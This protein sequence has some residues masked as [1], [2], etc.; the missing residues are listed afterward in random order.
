MGFA[1]AR[2]AVLGAVL[3]GAC[4]APSARFEGPGPLELL[5]NVDDDDGDGI[6]DG[7]D[8]RLNG[9]ADLGDLTPV[10]LSTRCEGQRLELTVEP[11]EHLRVFSLV[12]G[13]WVARPP[14]APVTCGDEVLEVEAK[15][16]RS[17]VWNGAGRLEVRSAERVLAGVD[18][19]VVPVLFPDVTKPATRLYAVD[20]DS[21]DARPNGTVV[22]A[23]E[24]AAGAVPLT[25][26]AGVDY[27]S[28]RWMQDAISA[29]VQVRRTPLGHMPTLLA[30]DRATGDL[31]LGSFA[32]NQ[33]GPDLGLVRAGRDEGNVLSYGGNLDVIPPHSGFALGR[34]VVGGGGA[35]HM[36][37]STR[38]WLEAQAAQAPVL[39]LSTE[40]LETGHL[41][42]VLT[43]VPAPNSKLGWRAVVASPRLAIRRIED[44]AQSGGGARAVRGRAG[45]RTVL[46][47]AGDPTLHR[48]NEQAQQHL[49]ALTHALAAATG[50][51]EA[52]IVTLPQ[53]FEV[54][55][56]G[57]LVPLHPSTVSVVV[58]GHRVLLLSADEGGDVFDGLVRERLA[59]LGLD[60]DFVADTAAYH[61]LGG[62][63]HCGVEIQRRLP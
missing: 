27:H 23:L 40:W 3:V 32:A 29:G 31:G 30:M 35:R 18:V 62:G 9:P 60:C 12:D 49:D 57:L 59:T 56:D 51:S 28:E 5:A 58:V 11:A 54:S 4:A 20:V 42:E 17:Q 46:E 52:D 55:R 10:T 7:L 13:G 15:R 25:L 44:L 6:R 47:L 63:L 33:L 61:A 38:A 1:R 39:E 21:P 14:R 50:Q 19:R 48:V 8:E 45:R 24:K 22:A 43:F 37:E 41:D 36:G 16:P 26:A 34:L 2:D 53:L